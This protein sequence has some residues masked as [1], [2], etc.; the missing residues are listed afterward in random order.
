MESNKAQKFIINNSINSNELWLGIGGHFDNY[1]QILCE[2]IDNSIS[3]FT[4]HPSFMHQVSITI[5]NNNNETVSTRIEDSGTGIQDLNAAFTIGSKAAQES[6]MNEHGFGLK[7]ALAA[8]NPTNDDWAIYTR[9]DEDNDK[10]QYKLIQ[11]PFSIG[12]YEAQILEGNWPGRCNTGTI[13]EFTCTYDMFK[14]TATGIRGGVTLFKTIIDVLIE[15]LGF[16][17]AGVIKKGRVNIQILYPD[18]DNNLQS[19]SVPAVEPHWS[20]IYHDKNNRKLEGTTHEDLGG[21]E[22]KIDYCF[23]KIEEGKYKKYYKCNQA[24]SGVEI[25]IN[26]RVLQHNIFKAIWDKEPH[27]SYNALLVQ[28]NL[29]TTNPAALPVTRTSKN[30][31]RSGDSKYVQLCDWIYKMMPQP[32]KNEDSSYAENERDLFA[33]IRDEK[34]IH[35]PEP[36]IVE[37]EWYAYSS[38]NESI[39]VDLYV[40]FG[41]GATIY[42]GKRERTTPKDAYQLMMYWDGLVYD[43]KNPKEAILISANHPKSVEKIVEEINKKYD[44]RGKQY[45]F[46]LKNWIDEGI[47]LS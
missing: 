45:N 25:R 34:R 27:N 12:E 13:V 24:S 28:I 19:V 47:N 16:V 35:L 20:K 8:A 1:A 14:T 46:I 40:E 9:T 36:N 21:G 31:L 33:K 17:Y 37:T 41:E 44:V 5:T 39:R 15:E 38:L 22:I 2:F 23:G 10:N 7:H 32:I 26:G 4:G 6:P 43:G 11:A 30:G 42:E 18:P 3:N 29:E